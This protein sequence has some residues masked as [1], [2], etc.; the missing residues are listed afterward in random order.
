MDKLDKELEKI[1]FDTSIKKKSKDNL[2][3]WCNSIRDDEIALL[4]N[5]YLAYLIF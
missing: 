1:S 4:S 3:N 2:V 5:M